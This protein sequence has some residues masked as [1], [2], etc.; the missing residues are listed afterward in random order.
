MAMQ[1][2][3]SQCPNSNTESTARVLKVWF[4]KPDAA[5]SRLASV[6]RKAGQGDRLQQAVQELLEGPDNAEEHSGLGSEIPRGTILLGVKRKGNDVELNLSR[7]FAS[8]GGSTS[9]LTRL[10][11]LKKTISEPAGSSNVYLSVEGRRLNVEE[12]EGIEIRQPINR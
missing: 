3:A 4:V 6:D 7:R 8:S 9:F 11:Q 10:D 5:G 1:Q 12:G 2:R